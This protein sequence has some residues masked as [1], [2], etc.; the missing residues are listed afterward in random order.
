[1]VGPMARS[2]AG[3]LAVVLALALCAPTSA[4]ADE[5]T[6]AQLAAARQLFTEGKEF[7]KQNQWAETLGH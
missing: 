6:E 2:L 7:E 1:M 5:P 4:I 3:R